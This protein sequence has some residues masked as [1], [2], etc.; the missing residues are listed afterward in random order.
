[1]PILTFQILLPPLFN[2][3]GQPRLTARCNMF[4]ALVMPVT[5]LAT[6]QYG[7]IGLAWGWVIAVPLLAI[8]TW[9]QARPL[10]PVTV[11]DLVR[12]LRPPVVA[13]LGMAVIV[14]LFHRVL[15]MMGAFPTLVTLVLVGV[16]SYAAILMV[17]ARDMLDRV[18]ALIFRREMVTT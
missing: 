15:P 9:L 3:L 11:G 16:A 1:M 12:A 13:A 10:V 18:I 14:S 4:G 17:T 7:A 8:F 2:A 5:Y 6:V